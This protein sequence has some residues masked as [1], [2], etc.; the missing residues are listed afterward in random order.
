L[1]RSDAVR[2]SDNRSSG[3]RSRKVAAP[4]KRSDAVRDSDNR[5]S[6]FRSRKVAA[7]LKQQFANLIAT[8]NVTFPQPKGCGPIEALKQKPPLAT[9]PSFPQPKGCGPI[10][11]P[12]EGRPDSF[13][14]GC[15]PIEA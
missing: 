2:D 6:G 13:R 14:L 4:L 3:F 11:A 12:L 9:R 1:K 5:S 10:E 15:G 8:T 7:P